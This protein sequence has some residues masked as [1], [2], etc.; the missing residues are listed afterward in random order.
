MADKEARLYLLRHNKEGVAI[1]ENGRK[2]AHTAMDNGR[3]FDVMSLPFYPAGY[4][5]DALDVPLRAVGKD[6]VIDSTMPC[7]E[8]LKEYQYKGKDDGFCSDTCADTYDEAFDASV[9]EDE[10]LG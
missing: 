3:D 5:P 7:R 8:C 10:E 6:G 4:E 9:E 1:Y 2:A